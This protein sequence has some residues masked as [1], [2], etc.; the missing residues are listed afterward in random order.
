MFDSSGHGAIPEPEDRG[1]PEI[2][3]VAHHDRR[4]IEVDVIE[5]GLQRIQ[6][7]GIVNLDF[8]QR[9]RR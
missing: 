7:K 1:E 6:G 5:A 8:A 4:S 3:R 2:A 9:R